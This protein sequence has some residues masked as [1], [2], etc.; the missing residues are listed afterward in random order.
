M[1]DDL[2]YATATELLEGYR[3][4]T[5]SPVEAT[6]AALS[7][8]EKY[9][10]ALN[11]FVLVD[12]DYA[13]ASARESEA[14]WQAGTPKGLVDG[15]PTTIKDIL[16]T[17]G[18]PTLR[19]SMSVDAAG[20]WNDDAPS[21][22]RL[23]EHG[24]VILGKTTSPEFG[25]KGVTDSPRTGITRN[26]WN[27]DM[28]PGGSSGGASAACA[29]GMGVLHVGTDGGGS[30]RIPAS[31]TGILGIKP[32]YGR[33]P[34]W[35]LSPFGTVAH[36]GPMTRTV[37]DSALMLRVMSGPDARDWTTLPF[38]DTDYVAALSA[39]IKGKR[40]AYS[41]TLGYAAV[42]PEVAAAV[43]RGAELFAELGA[44]VEEVDFLFENPLPIFNV[45]WWSGARFALR[46][47]TDKQLNELDP[48]L[49]RV[50]EGAASIT[51]TDY[52]EAV[53]ARGEL[54]NRMKQFHETY[55]LL[56][57]PSL[58]IPAFEVGKLAP[59]ELEEVGGWV[60]WTPFSYPFNLTQQP[61][62]SI[63]CGLNSEG[64]PIGLQIVGP[65]QD[66]AAVLNAAYAFERVSPVASA[67]PDLTKIV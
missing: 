11:A 40:V 62:C 46:N 44:N 10:G 57:T 17:K 14:R 19:G 4:G 49:R 33:V 38:V 18:W 53:Q 54:G 23:K 5:I 2:A 39:S 67:R 31:F 51:L 26:P 37:T 27:T 52:L 60:D 16:L 48:G 34:A 7:Q 1:T 24:A 15:V 28:T 42:D 50:F 35:P 43:K 12:E 13:L 25:W 59:T 63:P 55:D 6:Q 66:D 22:A 32:S 3:A 20:P 36:V 29:S 64:L 41:P 58:A 65:M 30:I 21:V 56:L 61:A 8:I 45:L 9:N 47:L